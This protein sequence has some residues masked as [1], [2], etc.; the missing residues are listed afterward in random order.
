MPS[1]MIFM[2][3]YSLIPWNSLDSNSNLIIFKELYLFF[4]FFFFI[5]LF[6]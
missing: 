1:K 4:F 5:N 3:I 6:P 2:P